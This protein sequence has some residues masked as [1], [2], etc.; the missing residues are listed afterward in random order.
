MSVEDKRHVRV[1]PGQKRVR[2]LMGSDYV[3]DSTQVLLVWEQPYYP[4][5]YF[6]ATDVRTDLL[7]PTGQTHSTRRGQAE[8]HTL[9]ADDRVAEQAVRWYRTSPL[10][11]VA[12]HLRFDWEA[13]DAW[14]EEDEQVYVHPR[15]PYTRVDILQSSR[16]VR[17][18]VDG[19][20]VAE[21]RMPRLL[22]ETDLP[23]RFYLPKT[24][25]RMDLLRPSDTHTSCPYK[26]VASYY[27]LIVN[28]TIH[29]DAVWWYPHP[30][31]EAASIAGY[32][33]FYNERVDLYV[34][35]E[36]QERPV[37]PFS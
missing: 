17:V 20:T 8:V 6:P 4:T 27:D 30:T 18:E 13:M 19:V 29:H 26:G 5:Y 7:T 1:E 31:L 25:V 14:F 15:N 28:G 22:F 16:H 23:A 10:E 24:D 11:G 9:R 12:D 37:T 34:V 2:V 33:A 3:A 35:G 36:L 21:S 32:V